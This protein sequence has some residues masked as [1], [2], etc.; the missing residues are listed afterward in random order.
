[1]K[2]VFH[3]NFIIFGSNIYFVKVL[4][5]LKFEPPT[6]LVNRVMSP[7][8]WKIGWKWG[9][10]P[11]ETAAMRPNNTRAREKAIV[12]YLAGQCDASVRIAT[13]VNR[14]TLS[15]NFKQW[16]TR[17]TNLQ[18]RIYLTKSHSTFVKNTPNATLCNY[19]SYVHAMERI[20]NFDS[21][22]KTSFD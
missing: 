9:L 10:N 13:I 15:E 18:R 6:I 8:F 5:D 20:C 3:H 11:R 14:S 16:Q 17:I 21:I 7:W 22:D 19:S 2:A 12:T 1:M 4:K